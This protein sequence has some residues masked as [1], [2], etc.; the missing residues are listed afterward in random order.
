MFGARRGSLR[1]SRAGGVSG[2]RMEIHSPWAQNVT[3]ALMEK[4]KELA[5]SVERVHFSVKQITRPG[6]EELDRL[7]VI[8]TIKAP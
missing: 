5:G 8:L 6:T 1:V 4:A 2:G 3:D 7:E